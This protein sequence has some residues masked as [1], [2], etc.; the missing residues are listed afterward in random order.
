MN[1][2]IENIGRSHSEGQWDNNK[3]G[4]ILLGLGKLNEEQVQDI[5]ALQD[6]QDLSFGAA[7]QKL[8]LVSTQDIDEAIA[9]QFN[10]AI[11]APGADSFSDELHVAYKPF[12]DEAEAIR[13]LRSQLLLGCLEQGRRAIAVMSPNKN[14]GTSYL[15]AN[16]AIS[17]AQL[18]LK[19]CLIDANLRTPRVANIFGLKERTP[20]L[21]DVLLGQHGVEEVILRN[22]FPN[23]G[24][25]PSG[26]KPPN[27]QELLGRHELVWML[28][29]L[30]SDFDVIL[31]DTPSM[32]TTADARTVAARVGTA[33][34]VARQHKTLAQDIEAATNELNAGDIELVGTVLNRY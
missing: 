20:G 30:L 3:I 2:N 6:S 1:K 31:F 7:A 13:A 25:I 33:L 24:V 23:L 32:N 10:Y 29:Q 12:G 8:N 17:F 27:P 22:L 28:S 16:L 26:R 5:L 15:T 21:S 14:S 18:G 4:Q 34:L 9:Q 11:L 19:A